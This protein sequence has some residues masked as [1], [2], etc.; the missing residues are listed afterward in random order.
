MVTIEWGIL[1]ITDRIEIINGVCTIVIEIEGW[2]YRVNDAAARV[3]ESLGWE[4]SGQNLP[5]EMSNGTQIED[6]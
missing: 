4:E 3:L 1:P 6:I 5:E 2:F